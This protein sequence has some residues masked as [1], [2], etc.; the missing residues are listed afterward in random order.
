MTLNYS[1]ERL[2]CQKLKKFREHW[3]CT[4]TQVHFE[5]MSD[6][7]LQSEIRP[8]IHLKGHLRA[9]YRRRSV[10]KSGK[11]YSDTVHTLYISLN[12]M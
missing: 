2:A 12:L 4:G 1:R 11:V 5:V 6:L 9:F 10:K 8:I 3:K 7:L